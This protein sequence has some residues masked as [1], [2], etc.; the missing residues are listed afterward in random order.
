MMS[1]EGFVGFGRMWCEK[2][3]FLTGSSVHPGPIT[4]C[5]WVVAPTE[6]REREN[7]AGLWQFG[8]F[9]SFSIFV[10]FVTWVEQV[11]NDKYPFGGQATES[12]SSF[13]LET[14]IE[15]CAPWIESNSR[16]ATAAVVE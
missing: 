6:D 3:D 7:T 1:G 11:Q 4:N 12:L 10:S 15:V 16:A 8:P 14:G 5:N 2:G 9:E 13:A